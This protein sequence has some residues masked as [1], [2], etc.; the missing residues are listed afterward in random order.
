MQPSEFWGLI[1]RSQLTWSEEFT[2]TMDCN[3]KEGKFE[4]FKEGKLN[5]AGMYRST[6]MV[7][8]PSPAE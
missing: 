4:W 7:K 5:A 8:Y 3:M 1:G 6:K 2:T